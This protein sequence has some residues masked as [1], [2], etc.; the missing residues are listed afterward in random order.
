MLSVNIFSSIRQLYLNNI[1]LSPNWMQKH[2][3]LHN[4]FQINAASRPF[5]QTLLVVSFNGTDFC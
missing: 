5:S 1:G 3:Y 4:N 2:K